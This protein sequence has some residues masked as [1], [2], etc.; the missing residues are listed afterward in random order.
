MLSVNLSDYLFITVAL[1][2]TRVKYKNMVL[3]TEMIE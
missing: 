3:S 2:V 1:Q